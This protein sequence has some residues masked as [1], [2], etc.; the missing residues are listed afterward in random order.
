M[1][2]HV[3]HVRQTQTSSSGRTLIHLLVTEGEFLNFWTLL[4]VVEEDT[5]SSTYFS[6]TAFLSFYFLHP[7][8]LLH[9]ALSRST[10]LSCCWWWGCWTQV[11]DSLGNDS[12]N[13][14]WQIHHF[15]HSSQRGGQ[16]SIPHAY[17][18]ILFLSCCSNLLGYDSVCESSSPQQPQQQQQSPDKGPSSSNTCVL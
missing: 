13:S 6:A 2:H 18:Q 7:F 10:L 15:H 5:V 14:W 11:L 17:R 3:W 8:N 16:T 1:S 9:V 4:V 12:Q